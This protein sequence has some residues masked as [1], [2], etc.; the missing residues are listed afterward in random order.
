MKDHNKEIR[1]LTE[2]VNNLYESV[3]E[4]PGNPYEAMPWLQS[5]ERTQDLIIPFDRINDFFNWFRDSFWNPDS[6]RGIEAQRTLKNF[7]KF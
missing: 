1:S 5:D 3:P 6:R 4:A 7:P 2:S